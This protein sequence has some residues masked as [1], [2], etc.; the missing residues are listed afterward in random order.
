MLGVKLAIHSRDA[1]AD[2][3]LSAATAQSALPGVKVK[4]A[5]GTTIELHETSISEGLQAVLRRR[6][7]EV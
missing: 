1:A 7:E 6:R 3:G 2:D 5:E 4:R